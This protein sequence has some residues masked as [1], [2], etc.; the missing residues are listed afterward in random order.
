MMELSGMI[1]KIAY[2]P[3]FQELRQSTLE[4]PCMKLKCSKNNLAEFCGAEDTFSEF[5][6]F[7]SGMDAELPGKQL[8]FMRYNLLENIQR[9]GEN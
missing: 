1:R 5:P 2:P 8:P 3:F 7:L 4:S 6:P 9:L